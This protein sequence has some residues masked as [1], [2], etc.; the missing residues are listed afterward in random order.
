MNIMPD[1]ERAMFAFKDLLAG[2]DYFDLLPEGIRSLFGRPEFPFLQQAFWRGVIQADEF[3]PGVWVWLE[4]HLGGIG[5]RTYRTGRSPVLDL[6]SWVQ[7]LN[8]KLNYLRSNGDTP[9]SFQV[10]DPDCDTMTPRF[11]R[12]EPV[13]GFDSACI[14]AQMEGGWEIT[15]KRNGGNSD[16][17]ARVYLEGVLLGGRTYLKQPLLPEL[18]K[19]Y[20]NGFNGV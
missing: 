13:P 8:A 16:W 6:F 2:S 11:I 1:P 3:K 20:G 4:L 15:R 18:P 14:Q 7:T 12:I 19:G 9:R 17:K 10:H 5:G